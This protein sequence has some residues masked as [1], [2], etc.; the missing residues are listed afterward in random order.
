M[1]TDDAADAQLIQ[2]LEGLRDIEETAK[3]ALGPGT[4][5][6]IARNEAKKPAQGNKRK[7]AEALGSEFGDDEDKNRCKTEPESMHVKASSNDGE[8]WMHILDFFEAPNWKPH[9]D[10][11]TG[12][13]LMEVRPDIMSYQT[14]LKPWQKTGVE[15]L[16]KAC[17]GPMRGLILGDETGLGKTLEALV[18]ARVKQLEMK[19]SCGFILAVYRPG[20]ILQWERET[21]AIDLDNNE[22]LITDLSS[23]DVAICSSNFLKTRYIENIKLERFCI[24]ARSLSLRKAKESYLGVSPKRA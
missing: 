5:S 6:F 7:L 12:N 10:I 21:K 1:D 17:D 8:K 20:C 23:F 9:L 2:E 3:R 15:K 24:V 13:L 19:P 18:A 16:L 22:M 14:M 4:F 11:M